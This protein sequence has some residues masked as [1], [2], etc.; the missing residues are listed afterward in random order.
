M[1]M[2]ADQENFVG[3]FMPTARYIELP[4]TCAQ[5]YNAEMERVH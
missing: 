4:K 1:P 3:N 5:V 2:W